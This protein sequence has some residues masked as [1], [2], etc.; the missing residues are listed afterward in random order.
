MFFR[1]TRGLEP[2]LILHIRFFTFYLDV[3]DGLA[4][5]ELLASEEVL[6][7]LLD[8][9]DPRGSSDQDDVIDGRLVDLGV[10]H[11]LLDRVQSAHEQV[12]TEL[13]QLGPGDRDVEVDAVVHGAD[14]DVGLGGGGKGPCGPGGV[15]RSRSRSRSRSLTSRMQSSASCC[16]TCPPCAS[17]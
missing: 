9:G 15:L 11:G 7:E 13:L 5:G 6:K 12:D 14:L 3:H 2:E 4:G 1:I 16:Q 10:P 8:F 17:S